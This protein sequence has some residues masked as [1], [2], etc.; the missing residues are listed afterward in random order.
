M[1]VEEHDDSGSPE[2]TMAQSKLLLR[3]ELNIK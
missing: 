3:K 2:I 1:E